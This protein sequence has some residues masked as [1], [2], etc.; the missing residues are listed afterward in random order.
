MLTRQHALAAI[1]GGLAA[2]TLPAVVRAAAPQSVSVGQ[3]GTSV[4]FFP[5]YVA[6]K[7]GYFKAANL[8]V[9]ITPFQSG[10]LVGTAVTS[11]SVDIGASVITDVFALLKANR[12]VKLV[13]S[14]VNGY[15]VDIIV[16]NQFLAAT[17]TSRAT[18]LADKVA[19]LKGKRIGI[20]GPGSGTQAL[21]DYLFTTNGLDTTRDAELVNVGASQASVIQL[22]KDGRIDAVS[23]AWP[24]SMIADA[25]GVGKAYI[26]PALG[27]VPTMREQIQSVIYAKPDVLAK[28]NDMVVA[29]VHAVG[30][31]EAY[32][33][34]NVGHARTML[35]AYDPELNDTAVTALLAAYLPVLP[36]QPQI[37]AN[38]YE[39]ALDFHRITGFAG[40]SGNSY[41]EVVDAST[42]IKALHS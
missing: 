28:R 36:E 42:I 31:A 10:T 20:T 24:L 11:N 34:R 30:R 19:A 32:L 4:A 26:M 18:K 16:S 14:L 2:T 38:N 22:L 12:P 3:I 37:A 21:V 29:F 5:L 39:K 25:A 35:K 33:H 41:A 27:D 1:A 40:P 23:F 17:K 6:D 8:D 13:G 9:T 7:L 15:Y